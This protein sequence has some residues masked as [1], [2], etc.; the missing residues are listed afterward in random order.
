MKDLPKEVV[1]FL[2]RVLGPDWQQAAA[3][4][5]VPCG[6]CPAHRIAGADGLP[7]CFSC[8]AYTH[9]AALNELEKLIDKSGV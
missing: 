8:P 9:H 1:S 6:D 5:R 4:S 2:Q 3:A 7:V